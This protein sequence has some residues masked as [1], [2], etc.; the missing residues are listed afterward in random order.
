MSRYNR[1]HRIARR[2]GEVNAG[3]SVADAAILKAL[4]LTGPVQPYTVD[5]AAARTLLPPGF[6]WLVII[7]TAKK[8]HASYRR[9]GVGDDGLPY[10]YQGQWGWT[11]PLALCGS[12]LRAW[13]MLERLE[14]E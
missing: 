5:E 3:H 14:G 4:G 13:A 7:R 12:A 11:I 8:V 6:E 9:I 1:L 10:P 2:L